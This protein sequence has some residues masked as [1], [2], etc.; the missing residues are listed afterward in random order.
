MKISWGYKITVVY[1]LFVAGILFLVFKA[2]NEN[3]DLVTK[4]YYGEELKYQQV[5]DQSENYAKLSNGLTVE[6]TTEGLKIK[7]PEEMKGKKMKVDFY[8]YYP[9][10]SKKDFRINFDTNELDYTQPL[11]KDF[12]G[13]YEFRCTWQADSLKYFN[14][15]KIFL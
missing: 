10:D 12:T 11:P 3:I 1:I 14:K 5:I 4:D 13:M 8:L 6:K 2:S 9:A 15:Q 7:F